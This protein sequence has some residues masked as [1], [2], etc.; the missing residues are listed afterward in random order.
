MIRCF[1][2][3]VELP[4]EESQVLNRRGAIDL[5]RSMTDEVAMLRRIVE[6]YSPLD[7]LVQEQFGA[8][9]REDRGFIMKKHR[10]L[11]PAAAQLLA[12]GFPQVELF[13]SWTEYKARVR[14]RLN[15]PEAA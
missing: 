1:M 6:Q 14:E 15:G 2:T 4:I 3:G 11:C 12:K 5:L 8:R 10:L 13:I 9:A 7:E